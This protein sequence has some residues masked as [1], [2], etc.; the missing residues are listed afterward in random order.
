MRQ[1]ALGPAR[2]LGGDDP[3]ILDPGVR[4]AID[5]AAAGAYERG[6]ADGAAAERQRAREL[7]DSVAG[8]ITNQLAAATD[9]LR[10]LQDAAAAAF[11]SAAL[12]LA[13]FV[14]GHAAHDGGS[15][16]EGRLSTAL[17]AIAD[18]RLVVTVAPDDHRRIDDALAGVADLA[19]SSDPSL[20]PGEARVAGRW[21]RA[22]LTRRAALD[23]AKEALS[24]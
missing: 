10:G 24:S 17:A 23:A 20:S 14:L 5:Q 6:L 22:D 9:E 18:D 4:A 21:A 8:A 19:V 7:D 1:P 3:R 15:A 16:L 13:E 12:E 2:P 11:V